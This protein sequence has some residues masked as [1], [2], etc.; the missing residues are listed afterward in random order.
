MNKLRDVANSLKAPELSNAFSFWT[1][2]IVETKKQAAYKE[3]L[4]VR[5]D[6]F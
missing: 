1:V 5:S 3:M 4:D 6:P 2:D